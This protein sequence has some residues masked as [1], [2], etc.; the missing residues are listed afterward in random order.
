M[1]EFTFD[2]NGNRLTKSTPSGTVTATYDDQDRLLSYGN[3]EYSYGANGEL[4]TQQDTSTGDVTD[5][6]YDARG[7]LLS[8]TLP[9]TRQL[10]YTIDGQARRVAKSVDGV[11]TQQFLY[12]D[13]LRVAAELN[14]AGALVSQFT[15]VGGNHSPDYMVKGGVTYRFIK[16][17]VGSPRLVVDVA[18]GTVAQRLDYDVF[19]VVTLDSNPGFQPF[20]FAGGVYDADTGFVRFGARDYDAR[21]G[22]WTA[23]DPIR[24]QGDQEN[25]YVYLGGDPANWV[26]P[27]GLWG[28][29]VGAGA[30]ATFGVGVAGAGG[31][32]IGGGGSQSGFF[33]DGDVAGSAYPG[34]SCGV[35]GQYYSG[36]AQSYLDSNGFTVGLFGIEFGVSHN[37]KTGDFGVS[38]GWGPTFPPAPVSIGVGLDQGNNVPLPQGFFPW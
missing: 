37:Q 15:Y 8:V 26:D 2:P 31:V 27:S 3:F 18:N 7:S 1:Q 13:Q 32:F 34:V 35:Y 5:Y 6:N 4:D 33:Y 30:S 16:D 11:T 25:L 23:K 29:A 36:D 21:T 12:K 19:G 22:R 28:I 10:E 38:L 17:Q 14:G 9:D 20:G 24:W